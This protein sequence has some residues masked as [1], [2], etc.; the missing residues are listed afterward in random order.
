MEDQLAREEHTVAINQL[1]IAEYQALTTRASYWI[2]LQ[3]SLLPVVPIYLALAVDVW[4]SDVII[5]EVVVWVTLAGLQL[6]GILWA[7]VLAEYYAAVKYI[8]CYLRPLIEK[9]VNTNLFWGY[10]PYL[11]LH[12]PTKKYW[13]EFSIPV[14]SL[15]VIVTTCYVR[16]HGY[17][18]RDICGLA[19]N[20][21]LF[22]YLWNKSIKAIRI[23][24]EWSSSDTKLAQRLEVA[25]REWEAA[26]QKP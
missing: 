2:I 18:W 12:R 4:R 20:L 17:T 15:G 23:M 19:S 24:R 10:E 22:Y 21:I 9:V 11:T 7:N 16:Y 3:A 5:R 1:H 8:E 6:I 13:G 25:R 14:L 26:K